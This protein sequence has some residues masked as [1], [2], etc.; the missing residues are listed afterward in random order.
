MNI[1]EQVELL[2]Q[3]TEYGDE[4][5]KKAMTADLRERLLSAQKEGRPLRVYCGYDPTSTDLHLGHTITMRKLRQFQDLG[6]EATFLIGSYTALVGDPSDKNKARPILTEEQVMDNART[7]A[8]QAFRV[9]DR[10]KTIIRY[11]GEWLSK[12]TLVDLIRLGQNF[13][14]Q[15]FLARD[16]FS[17]RLEKGEPIFLHETFYALMQGYD[18]VAMQT[19]VQVGGTDQL[20]NIIVAGRKLQEAL[21]QK[22]L[23]GI[24]CGI[25]PGTDG[26]QRMSKSTGNVV[27]INTDAADMYGK[28][29]SIP[30]SAMGLYYRLATR[31]GPHEIDAVEKSLADGTLHPR[32][33]KMRLAREIAAIFH[34]EAEADAAQANFVRTFQQRETPVEMEEYALKSGQTVLDVLMDAGLAESKSKARA[35]IDQKGVRLDGKTLERGDVPFP[36]A[37]VLQVGKRRF[38]RVR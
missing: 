34:G 35:L 23:V 22:P 30:D 9:L 28:V 2:M 18:A 32:D 4:D 27:P 14:V 6:H 12:L 37:G 11:N 3:G 31:F 15:Q 1:E 26:V 36:H 29:M 16:N 19:D 21:G 25:L 20:F 24:I 38:V 10:Q 33:A 17:N 13:T 7:Y 8:E 5:L